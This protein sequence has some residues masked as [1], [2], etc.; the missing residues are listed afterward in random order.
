[1]RRGI[2]RVLEF[3]RRKMKLIFEKLGIVILER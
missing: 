2:V 3:G 1:M